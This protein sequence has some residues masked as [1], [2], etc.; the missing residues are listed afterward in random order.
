MNRFWTQTVG[1]IVAVVALAAVSPTQAAFITTLPSWDGNQGITGFGEPNTATFGQTITVG[2]TETFLTN[3]SFQV[4]TDPTNISRFQAY[5]MAW[6]SINKVAVG[7]IL[8]QSA[9]ITNT[10]PAT[11][12]SPYNAINVITN[13][14]LTANQ[15]YVLF[16]NT[17]NNFD[18][19]NDFAAFGA[20]TPDAYTGGS[21]VFNNN[22][23]Q[24]GDLSTTPWTVGYPGDDVNPPTADLAFTA[25][26]Q[27]APLNPTPAPAGVVL[28]G[29]GFA[30]FGMFRSFRRSK[31]IA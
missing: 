6:D 17:S 4:A 16:F 18:N 1:A 15:E 24:F 12:P 2:A 26:L 3:F 27:D 11:P 5:V 25:N 31:V 9:V 14:Q 20:I 22:G 21:F 29:L 19:V 28:F 7:S 23:N 10:G 30:S 8:F 13:V